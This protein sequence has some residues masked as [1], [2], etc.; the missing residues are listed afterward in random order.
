MCGAFYNVNENGS[1]LDIIRPSCPVVKM[2]VIIK[3][4]SIKRPW[5]FQPYN[6]CVVANNFS[7][8][9]KME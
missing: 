6:L 3:W 2:I 8:V 5:T 7:K 1:V 4:I 9:V